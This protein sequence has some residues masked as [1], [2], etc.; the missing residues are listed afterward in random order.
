LLIA[1]PLPVAYE[2]HLWASPR[3]SSC[4][5]MDPLLSMVYTK[6]LLCQFSEPSVGNMLQASV[7]SR[8]YSSMKS[9]VFKSRNLD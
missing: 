6:K 7:V 9:H 3:F 8:A 2:L 1:G 4:P 5:V